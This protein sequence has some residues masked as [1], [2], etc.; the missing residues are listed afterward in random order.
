MDNPRSDQPPYF[1]RSKRLGF[2]PWSEQDLSLAIGLWGDTTERK[3]G[4]QYWPLFL[5]EDGEHVGCCGIRPYDPT[6]RLYELG[7]HIRSSYWG[8]GLAEEAASATI[9]Y[10]FEKLG[11]TALFAGHKPKNNASRRLL[12]KLG[13]QYTHA[14]L[15]APNGPRTPLVPSWAWAQTRLEAIS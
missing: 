6:Q 7:V 11:A 12:E 13:F 5:L 2:R 14:Q 3:H 8:R 9:D 1:L 4:V 15:Y 10:A